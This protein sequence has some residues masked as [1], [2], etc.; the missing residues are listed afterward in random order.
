M[1]KEH[2]MPILIWIA[3]VACILEMAGILPRTQEKQY[4]SKDLA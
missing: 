1:R 2:A 3:T 4:P